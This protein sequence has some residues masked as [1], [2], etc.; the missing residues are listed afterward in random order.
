MRRRPQLEGCFGGAG[1]ADDILICQMVEHVAQSA[2]NQLQR[3]VRKQAAVK[4]DAHGAFRDV[5]GCGGGLHDR[6]HPSQQGRGQFLKHAPDGEIE[7]VYMNRR[8]LKRRA[9]MLAQ[10][11]AGFRKL[12]HRAV[13]EDVRVRHFPSAFGSEYEHRSDSAVDVD[14]AVGLGGSGIEGDVVK[15]L[16]A[17]R[18]M[19]SQRFEHLGALVERH[20][21]QRGSA[22]GARVVQHGRR[23]QRVVA[24]AADELAGDGRPHR[25]GA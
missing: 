12:L 22:F 14:Q 9:D 19:Q 18:H 21:A 23:I 11:G 2:G 1:E 13:K 16:L 3:A 25:A 10:E 5:A 20:R 17:L 7:R 15:R 6:R 4:N 24:G 8:S